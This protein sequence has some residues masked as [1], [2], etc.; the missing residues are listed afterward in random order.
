MK[1]L[2]TLLVT[3]F[4]CLILIKAHA[5]ECIL[6]GDSA[7]QINK[8]NQ[9]MAM[10]IDNSRNRY[11]MEINFLNNELK[12]LRSENQLLKQKLSQIRENLK[13]LFLNL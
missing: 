4:T 13:N 12:K 1:R 8:Y 6:E 3:S 10:Q 7:F 2:K 5:N 11:Q 9:C